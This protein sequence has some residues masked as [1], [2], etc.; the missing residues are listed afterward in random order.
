MDHQ[1]EQAVW[2]RVNAVGSVTAEEALL[3]ERLEALLLQERADAASL[4][5]LSRSMNG[6]GSAAVARV[7]AKTEARTRTL[8]TLHYLLTGRR[9]R[10]QTPPCGKPGETLEALRAASLR[11]E[12]TVKTYER[13]AEEFPERKAL[14]SE[15]GCQS[16]GQYRAL[17]VQIQT[18]LSGRL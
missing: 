13:L 15:L 5:Q 1:T 8:V 14:F 18:M 9:L 12:Q 16:R 2:R 3:P 11:M 4:R 7:A 6:T 10:P 17:T